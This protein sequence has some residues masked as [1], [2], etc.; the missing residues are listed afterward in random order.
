MSDVLLADGDAPAQHAGALLL[1]NGVRDEHSALLVLESARAT[2]ACAVVL[3]APFAEAIADTATQRDVTVLE[4]QPMVSWTH[5][6][7]LVRSILDQSAGSSD[8]IAHHPVDY[9][10]LF[11]FADAAAAIVSAPVTIED[12]FS[13]VLAY[14]ALQDTADPVRISTIV[15]RRVPEPVVRH[16]RSRGVFRKLMAATEPFRVAAGDDVL[17]RLVVPVRAGREFLGSVWVVDPGV[18]SDD[19]LAELVRTASVI[20]L[21][22]LRLRAV[23]G[24]AR[25]VTIERLRSVLIT[26]DETADRLPAGPWRVVALGNAST[27]T[28]FRLELWEL[29]LRRLGWS[30][31]LLTDVD[32]VPV[33]LASAVG[34]LPGSWLWLCEAAASLADQMDALLAAGRQASTAADLPRSRADALDVLALARAGSVRTPVTSDD[35]W[36]ELVI[37]RAVASMSGASPG[38]IDALR[39]HDVDHSSDYVG[40][41]RE[42]LAYPAEPTRAAARLGIHPNTLRNRRAAI[43]ALLDVDL[44]DPRIRLALALAVESLSA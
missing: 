14:S 4:L 39:A 6:V 12:A 38:P 18:L 32:G 33:T 19:Q 34:R 9:G 3:R 36:H 26:G 21:H 10:E 43:V 35:V 27:D 29:T 41:L 16:F 8:A 5:F 44:D 17:E 42:I 31:P 23:F 25:R 20:A 40:T 30:Q 24:A 2:G 37:A 28:D 22:L 15:G 1:G 11:E 7:W 13:R